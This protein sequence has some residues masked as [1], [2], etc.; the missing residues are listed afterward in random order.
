MFLTKESPTVKRRSKGE[1]TRLLI[2]QS[3]T[4]VLEKME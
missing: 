1:K 3:A 2:L 4:E